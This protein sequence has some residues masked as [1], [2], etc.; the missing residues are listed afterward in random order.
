[1]DAAGQE[2]M[3]RLL[4]GQTPGPQFDAPYNANAPQPNPK[5]TPQQGGAWGDAEQEQQK[6]VNA[7]VPTIR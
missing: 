6:L 4:K 5:F 2:A 7:G 3:R 1:M